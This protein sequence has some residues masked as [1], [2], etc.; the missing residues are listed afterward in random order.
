MT[1]LK[2][3]K[4]IIISLVAGGIVVGFLVFAYIPLQ[5]KVKALKQKQA[6]HNQA[7]A[8]ASSKAEE[9]P[10]LKEQLVKLKRQTGN[11]QA[12]V[13][14]QRA[15][16]NFMHEVAVLMNE[17][18][19]SEQLIEP[20]AEIQTEKLICIPISMRCRGTLNQVYE[21]Y[22]SLQNLDRMVRI[23]NIR[24]SNNSEF[25]GSII[26]QTTAAIYYKEI[27]GQGG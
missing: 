4:Q 19:L 8:K 9:L 21:F 3:K 7:V 27:S 1:M 24:L 16:G 18:G 5:N 20:G 10:E 15:L 26:M 25:S 11:Y 12:K 6:Q 2:D 14:A 22:K 17:H 23:K 13:P